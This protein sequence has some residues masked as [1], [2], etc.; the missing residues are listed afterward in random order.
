M[1][2]SQDV[3]LSSERCHAYS[4][5]KYQYLNQAGGAQELC[6]TFLLLLL[7]VS[8]SGGCLGFFGLECFLPILPCLPLGFRLAVLLHRHSASKYRDHQRRLTLASLAS[9]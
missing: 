3:H 8:S 5:L 9:V 7:G 1:F 2:A 4:T 6:I